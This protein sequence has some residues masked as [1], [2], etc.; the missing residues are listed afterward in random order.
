MDARALRYFVAVADS[1]SFRA[2]ARR[3]AVSQPAVSQAVA[4]LERSLAEKLFDR[5]GRTIRLTPAGQDLLE[6]A[7][8]AL[9]ELD[10]LPSLL[11]R[12][13][14][15]VRGRLE[16]GT[17][18]VASIYVL[19]KVYRAFRR[20][21]PDAELS[22]HVEGS[23]PLLSLLTSGALELAI[24]SLRVGD[25]EAPVPP[26]FTAMPFFREPLEFVV[27]ANDALARRRR[28]TLADLA[29]VPLLGFK[30]DS[31]TRRAVDARFREE[32]LVPHVAMEMSSPEAIKR[33]VAVGLGASVLPA[34]SVAAE[35]RART[36]A[37][38]PVQGRRLERILGVVRDARRTPSPAAAAFLA[39]L[40]AIRNVDAPA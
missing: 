29:A 23:E 12:A 20:R 18:D 9:G 11:D 5:A 2:A 35:V 7:R 31:V 15:I 8:R 33:L 3:L 21:H 10:G 19:P 40:E 1:G 38:L 25:V 24:V 37:A 17:T 27:A 39:L 16:L 28:V 26:S 4:G 6:P 36:L 34:R 30:R 22:V 13:R 32:G 14:G